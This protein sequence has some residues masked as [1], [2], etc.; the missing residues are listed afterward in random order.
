MFDLGPGHDIP[1][2]ITIFHCAAAITSL[3]ITPT[4]IVFAFQHDITPIIVFC[5]FITHAS[6]SPLGSGCDCVPVVPPC[7]HPMA[8]IPSPLYPCSFLMPP[9]ITCWRFHCGRR[10]YS[11]YC[12]AFSAMPSAWALHVPCHLTSYTFY[13]MTILVRYILH[14]SHS[15]MLPHSHSIMSMEGG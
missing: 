7:V 3:P 5:C 6:L 10:E 2:G 15:D 8:F 4:P 9:S 1:P 12:G 14:A 11:D 13:L